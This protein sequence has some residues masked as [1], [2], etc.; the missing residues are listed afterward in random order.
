MGLAPTFD[1][2]L[3]SAEHEG[4]RWCLALSA[5]FHTLRYRHPQA[6]N[7][8]EGDPFARASG[9]DSGPSRSTGTPFVQVERDYWARPRARDPACLC[10][11]QRK[12]RLRASTN[13]SLRHQRTDQ[14][15]WLARGL[16]CSGC[17]V[18]FMVLPDIVPPIHAEEPART[19]R[20]F[21]PLARRRGRPDTSD[22]PLCWWRSA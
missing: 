1:P 11:Q 21:Y 22:L 15:S 5:S 7:L 10:G 12:R 18:P 9:S 13:G 4:D 6:K 19:A 14:P 3:R 20:S 2:V 17:R 8:S 16:T